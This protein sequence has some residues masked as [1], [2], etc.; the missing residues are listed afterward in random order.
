MSNFTAI[1][2]QL[3]HCYCELPADSLRGI[4]QC[5]GNNKLQHNLD[6]VLLS[7]QEEKKKTVEAVQTQSCQTFWDEA[8]NLENC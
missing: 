5:P 2:S 7:H 1:T 8:F 3:F 6:L 4:S